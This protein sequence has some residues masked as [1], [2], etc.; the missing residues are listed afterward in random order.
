MHVE[1]YGFFEF[2]EYLRGT[3]K[4]DQSLRDYKD[5]TDKLT[6]LVTDGK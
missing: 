4:E 1:K 3:F 6:S 5:L 2:T